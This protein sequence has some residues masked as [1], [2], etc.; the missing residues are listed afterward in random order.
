MSNHNRT[1]VHIFGQQYTI[2]GEEGA[3]HVNKV[4]EIVDKRMR[5]IRQQTNN[6]DTKQLAVL[7]AVNITNDYV[8]LQE[9]YR[10]LVEKKED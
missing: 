4:A 2:I 1:T 10:Q 9:K 5:E 7:T 8:K 3:G 6:L